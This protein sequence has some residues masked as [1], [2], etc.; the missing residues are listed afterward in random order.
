MLAFSN[1]CQCPR[2]AAWSR[3]LLD[4]LQLQIIRH[5]RVVMSTV[6]IRPLRAPAPPAPL[7]LPHVALLEREFVI[8]KIPFRLSDLATTARGVVELRDL[9]EL[10]TRPLRG[11]EE[12]LSALYALKA[13]FEPIRA[14]VL[15][16]ENLVLELRTGAEPAVAEPVAELEPALA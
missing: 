5:N 8:R 11:R 2:P 15:A 3:N 9:E 4:R 12:E 10:L 7:W 1:K 14:G 6:K 16:E 13:R